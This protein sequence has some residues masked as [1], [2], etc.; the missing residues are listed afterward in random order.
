VQELRETVPREAD[1]ERCRQLLT[2]V[3]FIMAL[4]TPRGSALYSRFWPNGG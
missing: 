4:T 2:N 1:R 3:E